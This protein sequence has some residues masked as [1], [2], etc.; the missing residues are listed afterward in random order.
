MASFGYMPIGSERDRLRISGRL[1]E[2]DDRRE[3]LARKKSSKTSH[4]KDGKVKSSKNP[5]KS[6]T[7]DV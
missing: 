2:H 5:K 7:S 1:K 4:R 3:Q 6:L